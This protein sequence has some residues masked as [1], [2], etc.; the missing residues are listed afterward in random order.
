MWCLLYADQMGLDLLSVLFVLSVLFA[1]GSANKMPTEAAP[2]VY[3]E[4]KKYVNSKI[5]RRLCLWKHLDPCAF[6]RH[7]K[8]QP[9]K[10]YFPVYFWYYPDMV[11]VLV[12][13]AFVQILRYLTGSD[14]FA[15]T[16]RCQPFSQGLFLL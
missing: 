12:C 2:H 5:T 11:I 13:P 10:I 6:R 14:I 9:Q 15:S 8:H 7:L 3:D 16:C 4:F 1:L